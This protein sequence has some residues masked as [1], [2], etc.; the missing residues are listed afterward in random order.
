LK[1]RENIYEINN[2][3]GCAVIEN[4]INGEENHYMICINVKKTKL[5]DYFVTLNQQMSEFNY[6]SKRTLISTH[7]GNVVRKIIYDSYVIARKFINEDSLPVSSKPATQVKVTDDNKVNEFKNVVVK[8]DGLFAADGDKWAIKYD[9]MSTCDVYYNPAFVPENA[10]YDNKRNCCF[11]FSSKAIFDYVCLKSFDCEYHALAIARELYEKCLIK[12]N[13][14][15]SKDIIY[16]ELNTGK[17]F[18]ALD[19]IRIL[20]QLGKL[21]VVDLNAINNGEAKLS[22]L[23]LIKALLNSTINTRLWLLNSYL[24]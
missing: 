9:D 7:F 13:A 23:F 4:E 1:S 3:Q 24:I 12:K 2:D 10:L 6:S 21:N 8:D 17:H 5:E 19:Y 22:N 16:N 11:K 14:S 20:F 15:R 18:K